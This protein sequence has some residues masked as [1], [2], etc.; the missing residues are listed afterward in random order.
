M[1]SPLGCVFAFLF[2]LMVRS[3]VVCFGGVRYVVLG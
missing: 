1:E 2:L 3:F